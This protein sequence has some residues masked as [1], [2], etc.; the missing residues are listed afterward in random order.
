MI[1]KA[2][3]IYFSKY[4]ELEPVV[5]SIDP[6][7]L[8]F[9]WSSAVESGSIEQTSRRTRPS[10]YVYC[11]KKL[12]TFLWLQ[13]ILSF[14]DWSRALGELIEFSILMQPSELNFMLCMLNSLFTNFILSN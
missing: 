14:L 2:R 12:T 11:T 5:Y 9:A 4:P 13:Y 8:T 6:L 1:C 3:G 10:L 7:F